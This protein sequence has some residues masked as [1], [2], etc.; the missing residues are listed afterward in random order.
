VSLAVE[1]R[2]L[3]GLAVCA[4]AATV[5]LPA[6][7]AVVFLVV[8]HVR[9]GRGAARWREVV[10]PVVVA[11]AVFVGISLACGYGFS[12]LGPS[13]LHVPTELRIRST[14]SVAVGDLVYHLLHLLQVPALQ[15][16]VVTVTQTVFAL[17]AVLGC[18]WL[19]LTVHRHEVVRSLGLAL[20]LFVVASPTV[21]PWYLL[22]GLVLL[23]ATT[24]Q[25]SKVLAAVAALAMLAVGAGGV[26]EISGDGYLVVALATLGAVAWMVRRGHWRTVVTGHTGGA[27]AG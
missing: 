9:S 21:W 6:A 14:P 13:A 10:A 16:S 26:P 7:G 17:A 22:W 23:A 12:W 8:N 5:K 20:L 18:V 4:V 25:R 15:S 19:L 2:L 3:A 11:S 24:A 1:G 27:G